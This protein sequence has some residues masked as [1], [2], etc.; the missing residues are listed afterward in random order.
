MSLRKDDYIDRVIDTKIEDY[1]NLFGAVLIEGPKWCGKTWT[2]LNHAGS[3][4][5]ILDP[6]GNYNNRTLAR[7]NPALVL[8]GAA[9]RLIDEW[10]EVPGIWDAV[11]F[12]ID[13]SPGRGKY[14]LTGSVTPPRNLF[15]HSGT[16]RIATLRMRPMSLYESKDSTG[17]VSLDAIFKGEKY[18][19]FM[20]EM[21]I[22]SLIDLTIRGGWPETL[23][24]PSE[25]AGSIAVEIINAIVRN[26]LSHEGQS[27]KNQGKM[28]KLLRS[29][30]RNNST[31][32]TIKTLSMDTNG[33]HRQD[34]KEDEIVASRY[35]I[36]D[37]LK[38]LCE[39]FIIDEIPPWNPDIR[40]KVIMRQASKRIYTDPSLAIASLGVG[41]DRMLQDLH[42]FGF[43]FENLC[44]RDL[45][46]YTGN[47]G[48]SVFHY[49]D[50]SGLEVDA[51]IELPGGAWGAFEIKLGAVQIDSA[52]DTLLRMKD[53]MVNAGAEP[54]S[55]LV[56]LTG[57]GIGHIRDD[58]VYVVPINAL[59]H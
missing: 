27:K 4:L 59:R 29:I 36:A 11:R 52:A 2:A 44:L 50:N 49:R 43:M 26:E 1:L 54:P 41:R 51:I 13:Q 14:I 22:V 6:A 12:D 57:G 53:K 8:P 28:R 5:F 39:S 45:S 31:T 24:L 35:A 40:S 42:T 16:G 58:G 46:I 10:Q 34:Q 21:D 25:K 3:T 48:G 20:S 23:K 9:P 38:Q 37:Y 17:K 33:I 30:A 18:D 55:C 19:P 47:H 7:I 32:A 15:M 56:V